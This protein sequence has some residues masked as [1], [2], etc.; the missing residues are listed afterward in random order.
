MD[1]NLTPPNALTTPPGA[2]PVSPAGVRN[3]EL[4]T[5]LGM[6]ALQP[7]TITFRLEGDQLYVRDE[8]VEPGPGVT[9]MEGTRPWN[10]EGVR[11][12][13]GH[14]VGSLYVAYV[15]LAS[16]LIFAAA[17]WQLSPPRGA[18]ITTDSATI[19]LLDR[20]PWDPTP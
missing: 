13:L 20:W 4:R 8:N 9:I 19:A 16:G 2:L 14:A 12:R 7:T 5:R 10:L 6:L 11:A 18:I 1:P 3:D 15:D 17:F